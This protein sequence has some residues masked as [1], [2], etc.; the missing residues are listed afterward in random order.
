M[1]RASTT[2]STP[3]PVTISLS[4]ASAS[5]FVSGV[6]GTWWNGMPYDCTRVSRSRWFDTTAGM[7]MF[8]APERQRNSRSLRQCPNRLTMSR[9]W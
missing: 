4:R 3:W 5:G 8:T 7:S 2:S 1:Y 6:T 9:A